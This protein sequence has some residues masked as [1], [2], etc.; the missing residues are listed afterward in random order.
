MASLVLLFAGS[1]FSVQ[2]ANSSIEGLVLGSARQPL[3]QFTVEVQQVEKGNFRAVI[4]QAN[5]RYRFS[6]L[7]PGQYTLTVSSSLCHTETIESI[8][9]APGQV[10]SVPTLQLTFEGMTDCSGG[11]RPSCYRLLSAPDNTG[12]LSGT[13]V[14]GNG[15]A[16]RGA[17][18]TLFAAGKQASRTRTNSAG[19]FT[20]SK[21]PARGDYRLLIE[22][23]GFFAEELHNLVVQG[24]LAARYSPVTLE[25]CRPGSCDPHWKEVRV[26]PGCA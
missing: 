24:G 5:G 12:A 22:R 23:T 26:L 4:A 7:P 6:G 20:I 8:T 10:R 11:F 13:V 14:D 17:N 2:N 19:R 1:L 15:H 9:V 18:V 3:Q 25:A 21:L 16:V